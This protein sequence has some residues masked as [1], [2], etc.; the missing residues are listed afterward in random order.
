M[1][2]IAP[3][4]SAVTQLLAD[5]YA[6]LEVKSRWYC[7]DINCDGH[8]HLGWEWKHCRANQRPPDSDWFVWLLMS[9]RR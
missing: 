1:T 4:L 7:D 5:N 8:A 9:G 2:S 3:D 6:P